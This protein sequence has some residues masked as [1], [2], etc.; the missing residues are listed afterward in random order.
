VENGR[1]R[2]ISKDIF[3]PCGLRLSMIELAH[4]LQGRA[5]KGVK[6]LIKALFLLIVEIPGKGRETLWH[7]HY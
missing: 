7:H 1:R 5:F 4:F 2:I 3:L 6:P